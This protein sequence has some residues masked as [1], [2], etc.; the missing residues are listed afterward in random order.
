MFMSV[1]NRKGNSPRN[2][3]TAVFPNKLVKIGR[4]ILQNIAT[5]SRWGRYF[6]IRNPFIRGWSSLIVKNL[7]VLNFLVSEKLR[8]LFLRQ[9]IFPLDFYTRY[10]CDNFL[11]CFFLIL[12]INRPLCV[13]N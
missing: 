1:E 7:S 3:E 2:Y 10:P 11:P 13:K 5:V 9:N 6:F 8:N 4:V 12:P